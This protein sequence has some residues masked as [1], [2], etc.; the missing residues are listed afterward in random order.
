MRLHNLSL[1][2]FRNYEEQLLALGPEVNVFCGEN[3]Q[4]KTNALEAMLLLAVG[5][6]HRTSKDKDMVRWTADKAVITGDIVCHSGS[7]SLRLELGGNGRKAYINRLQLGKMTDF[8]GHFQVV[9]FAPEDLQLVKAGPRERR[10]FLD[11][12]LGQT[13]PLYLH[14]LT[15]YNRTLAQRNKLLKDGASDPTLYMS[16]DAQL[17]HHGA[18]VLQRRLRFLEELQR[19]AKQIYDEISEGR[20]QFTF[21]YASSIG[22][23]QA[24]H[25]IDEIAERIERALLGKH[26]TDLR[27]GYTTVGPHRDDLRL[28][29]NGQD[30]Q[31]FASQGQQRTI[32]LALRLA[33]IDFMYQELGEY[34]V[35]L[36][37]D[38]LSELDDRRQRNLVL[39]MSRK[40]QTMI[41]TTSLY[42]LERELADGARL[43]R[44]ASG[45][46]SCDNV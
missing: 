34:P 8:I 30:V 4:G 40:V 21:R 46:I 15:H 2:N 43:F 5:K 35:L 25:S 33:E 10:R 23:V 32:A 31:S 3:G 38:V 12:E 22:E 20:E 6:S 27:M 29:L 45:I 1:H 17:A 44:V 26:S 13:Q 41:T 24:G 28:Y 19:Y 14:H 9:L 36:L 42:H 18:H 16:F 11:V 7:R 39:S 37:D